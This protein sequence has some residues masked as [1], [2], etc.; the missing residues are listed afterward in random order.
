MIE[1]AKANAGANLRI[2]SLPFDRIPGQSKLFL[3]Y[4]SD[5]L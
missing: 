3:Q 4:Q 2:E 5:P 1:L